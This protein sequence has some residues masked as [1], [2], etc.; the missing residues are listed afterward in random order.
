MHQMALQGSVAGA[1]RLL[2]QAEAV[3]RR[4]SD[5][6]VAGA[7]AG[8]ARRAG[9]RPRRCP[10]VVRADTP[11]R[12]CAPPRRP[13]TRR[14]S[15]PRCTACSVRRS[16]WATSPGWRAPAARLA[17]VA[18]E[19]LFPFAIVRVGPARR[20]ARASPVASSRARRAHRRS[21]GH[22]PRP[23]GWCRSAGRPEP[24]G[25]CSPSSEGQFEVLAVLAA[26]RRRQRGVAGGAGDRPGR[27][28]PGRGGRRARPHVAAP[29]RRRRCERAAG[30][31]GLIAAILDRR[32]RRARRRRGS[33]SR[34]RP[35]AS[36]SGA[37]G[38]RSSPTPRSR[39]ALSTGCSACWPSDPGDVDGAVADL[40]AAVAL[41]AQSPLWLARCEL[42]LATALRRSRTPPGD[43]GRGRASVRR[44]VRVAGGRSGTRRV[45][46]VGV[47]ASIADRQ[48]AARL[49]LDLNVEGR[50]NG[51][52]TPA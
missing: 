31:S 23:S 8:R 24:S 12:R 52:V 25:R 51:D 47:Q 1:A 28:R 43:A 19:S 7:R 9:R 36:R 30:T 17:A 46:V 37:G 49:D 50:R 21:R 13:V 33:R 10:D 5:G 41:A 40:R 14:S 39:S 6:P 20:V 38:S 27:D 42:A 34:S 44:G 4:P 32:G 35:L 3:G 15:S 45:G 2:A 11:T 18:T 16:S 48:S 26:A 29:T 22:R